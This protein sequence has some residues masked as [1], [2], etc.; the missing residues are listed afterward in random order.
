M[1]NHRLLE[2]VRPIEPGFAN[3]LGAR[4]DVLGHLVTMPAVP[5]KYHQ[6]VRHQAALV[7]SN[8]TKFSAVEYEMTR[9]TT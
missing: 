1:P 9:G 5:P 4:T 8:G 2:I 3:G 6:T 7:S